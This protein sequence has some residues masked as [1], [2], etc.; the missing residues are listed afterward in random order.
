MI[1][2]VI[3]SKTSSTLLFTHEFT[4]NVLEGGVSANVRAGLLQA[5][6]EMVKTSYSTSSPDEVKVINE[7]R[8]FVL[9]FDGIFVNGM[10]FTFE[11]GSDKERF[12]KDFVTSFENKF[13]STLELESHGNIVI[14]EPLDFSRD[15]RELYKSMIQVD[16][17]YLSEVIKLL[18]EGNI[19]K[20]LVVYSRPGL[21]PIFKRF[22]NEVFLGKEGELTQIIKT[23]FELDLKTEYPIDSSWIKFG[24]YRQ[25]GLLFNLDLYAV[26]VFVS[27]DQLNAA[28]SEIRFIKQAFEEYI[29]EEE[30]QTYTSN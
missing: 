12:L 30:T 10:L 4:P 3:T 8:Y 28:T 24:R 27:Q 26:S 11:M 7:G 9:L 13:Y 23:I 16:V 1:G 20:D 29:N 19:F 14:A 17:T 15:C 2:V 18:H 25:Y 22:N 5:I 6:L 21:N